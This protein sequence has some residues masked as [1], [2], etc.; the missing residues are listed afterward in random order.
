MQYHRIMCRTCAAT[1]LCISQVFSFSCLSLS[2]SKVRILP[3]RLQLPLSLIFS[4]P[5]TRPASCVSAL[6][7]VAPQSER[8]KPVMS[9]VRWEIKFRPYFSGILSTHYSHPCCESGVQTCQRPLFVSFVLALWWAVSSWAECSH[10]LC[11]KLERF[12]TSHAIS[13]LAKWIVLLLFD[14]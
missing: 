5:Q 4:Q 14:H 10:E 13:K 2:R 8:V 3:L 12:G 1:S 7:T 9:W 6:Q 11:V